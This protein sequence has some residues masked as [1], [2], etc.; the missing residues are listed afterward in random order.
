M[1][2]EPHSYC[3]CSPASRNVSKLEVLSKWGT[4]RPNTSM[5]R[6]TEATGWSVIAENDELATI[7]D[8]ALSMDAGETIGR[9]EL[10]DRSGIALKTLHLMDDLEQ[11]V[12]LGVLE[13]QEAESEEATYTVNEDSAVLDKAREFGAAVEAAQNE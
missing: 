5:E 7:I 3:C 12:E 6:D 11:V 9:S 1:K 2:T 4:D 8:T 10:A 13:K